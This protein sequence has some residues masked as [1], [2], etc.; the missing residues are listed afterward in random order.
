MLY[1]GV[2]LAGCQGHGQLYSMNG[3]DCSQTLHSAQALRVK[4]VFLKRELTMRVSRSL[5]R[6]SWHK[7][8]G[9]ARFPAGFLAVVI[10][11]CVSVVART[12][13]GGDARCPFERF[14]L[15]RGPLVLE[16]PAQPWSHVEALGEEAGIWGKVGGALE[17]WVYPFKLFHGLTLSFSDDG[18]KT[19]RSSGELVRDQ[20]AAPHMAQLRLVA[21]RFAL[22]ET[23]FVPRKLPGAAILLDIDTFADLTIAVRF[24][25]SLAPMLMGVKEKPTVCWDDERGELVA[26]EKERRVELRVE[27]PFAVSHCSLSNGAEEIR[28]KVPVAEAQR[29]F[30]PILFGISWPEGSSARDTINALSSRPEKLFRE[31][32]AHYKNLLC[33]APRVISPDREVNDALAWSVVSLDQLRVRNPFLGYGLV[34]GYSSSGEGTRPQYAWFFD[35]PTLSS[36]AFHRAGLSS[37]V[38]EAFRFLQRF[39]RADGKTV[40]EITQS[41]RYQPDFLK[42][43][44]YAYIHTDGPVYFL[45]A[46]GHYYRS[47]GDLQFIREEWPKILKTLQWCFSAVDPSDGLIEIQPQDWGSA[48]SSFAVSK[49]TQLEGMWVQALR[50][51]ENL[52]LAL[53]DAGVASRCAS[54]EQKA[55]R[56]IERE[57]WN[58]KSSTYLWG[59]DRSGRPLESLVPHCAISIWMGN[60]RSDRAERVLEKMASAD[61]RTDWGVR[62]LSLS[63]P[64]YDASA[65]QSGS[66]WPVWNAGVIIGD[67]RHHR[68]VEAFRNWL[69]MIR[70]RTLDGLGPMPEVLH[71]RYYKR[72]ER[73]A[74]HQMFSELAVQNGFYDGLLGLEIDVPAVAVK[75]APRLPPIWDRLKVER[76][77]LGPGALDL[78]IRRDRR[79]YELWLDLRFPGGAEV[80]LEPSLPAGSEVVAVTVD[81]DPRLFEK[82]KRPSATV[83]SVKI[84]RFEG[85]RLLR[86]MHSG[87]IDFFP[88]DL[89]I[90]LGGTSQNLRII[91]AAFVDAEWQM[92][93]E[94]LPNRAY[95]IDFFTDRKPCGVPEGDSSKARDGAV[96]V[97][98]RPPRGAKPTAS[99]FVR[100][101]TVIRWRERK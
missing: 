80:T 68:A 97:V 70:L 100:W 72:L 20:L 54:L 77:P 86:I 32:L 35:E 37:H 26:F 10:A 21:D 12:D 4:Y 81:G 41:L 90:A 18:G 78:R 66:V 53:G 50:E 40:H 13:A 16:R 91:R 74:P 55:S 45:A 84:P 76:I 61:F 58:E 39:Q 19:F 43:F 95:S 11:T 52:A 7:K 47:T 30:V 22:T 99:G 49:D 15:Y 85:R 48:E 63:D 36:W 98:L 93:L 62:S 79:S 82:H 6:E 73:G 64:A 24:H 94:G 83:V 59:L 51:M 2:K 25:P 101:T 71:G 8:T 38:R 57:L 56:S 46:Y 5:W 89:P 1:F 33:G 27:S 34:S 17:A 87:G 28:L 69:A 75:L 31:A 44:P 96:R 9:R 14:R 29:G 92:I 3:P 67:Y 88:V 65:Y 60:F 42:T 23:L